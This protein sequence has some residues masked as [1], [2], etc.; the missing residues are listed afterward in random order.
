M[1]SSPT[2][3]YKCIM[4]HHGGDKTKLFFSHLKSSHTVLAKTIHLGEGVQLWHLMKTVNG[5]WPKHTHTLSLTQIQNRKKH[6]LGLHY[7]LSTQTV[8]VLWT[9]SSVTEATLFLCR[10]RCTEVYHQGLKTPKSV[11]KSRQGIAMYT[12]IKTKTELW[13]LV[14]QT[15]FSKLCRP[16]W[17]FLYIS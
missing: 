16:T 1:T 7:S 15:D 8:V 5:V 2:F 12:F 4:R 13:C 3:F 6:T 17:E 9:H 11:H 14:H 10:H